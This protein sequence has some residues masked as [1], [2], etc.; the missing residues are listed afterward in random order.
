MQ[1]GSH[2][3]IVEAL[4]IGINSP[5]QVIRRDSFD[6]TLAAKDHFKSHFLLFVIRTKLRLSSMVLE[7]RPLEILTTFDYFID[8]GTVGI[9]LSCLA[10]GSEFYSP[11]GNH[12]VL[13]M[14]VL[15]SPYLPDL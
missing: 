2:E 1:G 14:E 12:V 7:I 8:C 3:E 5:R 10:W 4:G 6:R 11:E 9:N 13:F 15:T